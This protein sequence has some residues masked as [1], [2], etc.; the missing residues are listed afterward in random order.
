MRKVILLLSVAIIMGVTAYVYWFYY[1]VYSD[2]YREGALQKFSRRG[3]LFKTFEGEMVQLGFG[4]RANTGLVNSN[5]FYFSVSDKGIADSL[6]ANTGRIVKLHYVQY[7]RS[8][9]WRGDNYNEKNSDKGQY[10]VDRIVGVD[11]T[12]PY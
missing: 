4:Q 7:R 2:G 10:I 11:S 8:L 1:S 3:N 9:P 12:N 5:Y 6:N